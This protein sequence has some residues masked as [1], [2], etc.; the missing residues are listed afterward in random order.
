MFLRSLLPL[1]GTPRRVALG[2]AQRI[3]R[4]APTHCYTTDKTNQWQNLDLP[5]P[6]TRIVQGMDLK[7]PLPIQ[8]RI[9]PLAL[10]G[11]DIVFLAPTGSGKTLAYLLPT[12]MRL[13]RDEI[14][15]PQSPYYSP[16]AIFVVP[17]QP[18]AWQLTGIINRL[19][20][21]ANIPLN[22]LTE[23]HLLGNPRLCSAHPY[24]FVTTPSTISLISPSAALKYGHV[25]TDTRVVVIDEFDFCLRY[26]EARLT[27]RLL[28]LLT[29]DLSDHAKASPVWKKSVAKAINKLT[30]E[31]KV[32]ETAD[33]TT[34]D[35]NPNKMPTRQFI[36][37]GATFHSKQNPTSPRQYLRSGFPKAVYV[38]DEGS[39]KIN[40]RTREILINISMIVKKNPE[41]L[42]LKDVM[43]I[44]REL[45][46]RSYLVSLI[47]GALLTRIFEAYKLAEEKIK[48]RTVLVFCNSSQNAQLYHHAFVSRLGKLQGKR[49]Y[50]DVDSIGPLS[51]ETVDALHNHNVWRHVYP[52]LYLKAFREEIKADVIQKAMGAKPVGSVNPLL[53]APKGE[54]AHLETFPD[55]VVLFV[56]GSLERGMD[57]PNVSAVLLADFVENMGDYI[58]RAGRTGR[59]GQPGE[60]K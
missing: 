38:R 2:R 26:S 49:F 1:A 10:Q 59:A 6:I 19:V 32:A 22:V 48:Q 33:P 58:H 15:L 60:G 3:V 56:A 40:E 45:P 12:L 9:L 43:R 41:I 39:F 55:T 34:Q 42:K 8:K 23:P 47:L 46:T 44:Y 36:F 57:L 53:V 30:D 17:N 21:L 54:A 14:P 52:L 37:C 20:K 7:N 51:Q 31:Q 5:L 25:F 50:T 27:H 13:L 11:K 29:K 28:W 24:F 4:L 18:L 35:P 16:Y